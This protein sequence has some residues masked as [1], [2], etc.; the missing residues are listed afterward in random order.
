VPAELS[1]RFVYW[2]K[3][4]NPEEMPEDQTQ[5]RYEPATGEQSRVTEPEL[6]DDLDRDAAVRSV[7]LKGDGRW[8]K[9]PHGF[10]YSDGMGQQ[11]GLSLQ[12]AIAGQD[13]LAPVGPGDM[14]AEDVTG[15]TFAF[16]PPLNYTDKAGVAWLVQWLDDQTVM[17]L[18]PLRQSTNLIACHVDTKTCEVAASA[19]AGIVVP[20]FGKSQFIG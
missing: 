3:D 11:V 12:K 15:H 6:L 20:D 5:V 17:V 1:E 4:P 16:E 8:E 13:G 14:V 18:S 19:P 9:A 2:F 7:R 10:H